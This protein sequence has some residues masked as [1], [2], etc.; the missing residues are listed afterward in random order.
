MV[1][2]EKDPEKILNLVKDIEGVENPFYSVAYL[3]NSFKYLGAKQIIGIFVTREE[4]IIGAL[5]LTEVFNLLGI[6]YFKLYGYRMANY[7]GVISN[8][9]NLEGTF[10]E[11][12]RY[13]NSLKKATIIKFYD[14]YKQDILNNLLEKNFKN[15]KK[16]LYPCPLIKLSR[17]WDDFF[18]NKI[19]KSKKRSE[20][21]SFEKK[22]YLLGKVD[23]I[24]IKNK[25]DYERNK[26]Y[27]DEIYQVH[28]ERFKNIYVP[29]GLSREEYREYYNAL[30]KEMICEEKMWI[31][32]ILLDDRVISFVLCMIKENTLIDIVPAFDPAFSSYSLGTVHLKMLFEFL[33]KETQYSYF[34]FSKG[35]S[36]YK[37]RWADTIE[38]NYEYLAI[39]N[40]N[41]ISKVVYTLLNSLGNL[42]VTLREKGILKRIKH[43]TGNIYDMN[44]N[45][46]INS[47]L[48]LELRNEQ[49]I[50][51]LS[52]DDIKV[53][54]FK[55]ELISNLT[56]IDK[57]I[58]LDYKYNKKDID[59]IV[60]G[61]KVVQVIEKGGQK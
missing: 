46:S 12:E 43:F 45:K 52:E 23:F 61:D 56:T 41:L 33:C 37:E 9:E 51:M 44:L 27:I 30:I 1:I 31:S 57:K 58:I 36:P 16:E 3:R 59:L 22:L 25:E 14:I 53:K 60:D 50:K 39:Y 34:D 11:I 32:L 10:E 54:P 20:L 29:F 17:D 19:R 49:G 7:L 35:N 28:K 42:K 24:N 47:N 40:M 21:K 5:L 4:E 55:Y 18:K 48:T 8:I 38:A 26:G 15:T 6:Q 13:F 2:I